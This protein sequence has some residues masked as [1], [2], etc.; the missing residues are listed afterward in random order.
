MLLKKD[1]SVLMADGF[2]IEECV[3]E[4]LV[5]PILKHSNEIV[6]IYPCTYYLDFN[7]NS[8][9]IKGKL[10]CVDITPNFDRLLPFLRKVEIHKF[11]LNIIDLF[12][13]GVIQKDILYTVTSCTII[14][15][16]KYNVVILITESLTEQLVVEHIVK[17]RKI[18]KY[19]Y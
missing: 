16:N 3:L 18:V 12:K 7:T 15:K 19:R 1:I 5:N 4:S 11:I 17:I 2:N 14:A 8:L 6:G 13:N 10:G 9:R